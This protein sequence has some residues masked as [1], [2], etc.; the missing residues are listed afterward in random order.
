MRSRLVL[1]NQPRTGALSNLAIPG[2]RCSVIR[3]PIQLT[4]ASYNFLVTCEANPAALDGVDLESNLGVDAL[5][6][7]SKSLDRPSV[8]FDSFNRSLFA[9]P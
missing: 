9:Q 4:S 3:Q 8:T 1:G 7:S 5:H 6:D 2:N